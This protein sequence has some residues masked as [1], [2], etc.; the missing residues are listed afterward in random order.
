MGFISA[1]VLQSLIFTIYHFFPLQNA[2]L[3]FCMGLLF[4]LGYMWSRSLLTP[5][6]AH[7]LLNGTGVVSMMV[8]FLKAA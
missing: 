4:G 8:K 6:L 1:L 3:L 2:V 5:I 7:L